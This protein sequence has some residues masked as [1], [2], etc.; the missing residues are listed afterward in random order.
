MNDTIVLAETIHFEGKKK[1]TQ[2]HYQLKKRMIPTIFWRLLNF[3]LDKEVSEISK[4]H[5][6]SNQ[7]KV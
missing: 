3:I 7:E 4:W 2:H 5:N 6:A 1:I